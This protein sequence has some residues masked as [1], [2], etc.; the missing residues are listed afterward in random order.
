MAMG[1]L[2]GVEI[3]DLA[4]LRTDPGGDL[5]FVVILGN[6]SPGP[7]I[8]VPDLFP[9]QS[10]QFQ[11]PVLAAVFEFDS[12][13]GPALYYSEMLE[14]APGEIGDFS[15]S[16][17]FKLADYQSLGGRK[18]ESPAIVATPVGEF[19][20]VNLFIDGNQGANYSVLPCQSSFRPG[21]KLL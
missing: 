7:A 4:A 12:G 6:S 14:F 17:K 19:V 3:Y 18:E 8:E 13:G 15:P 1:A 10:F 2:F 21:H 5:V 11:Y 9:V 20:L 16:Q